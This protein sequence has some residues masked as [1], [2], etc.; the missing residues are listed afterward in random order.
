MHVFLLPPLSASIVAILTVIPVCVC[1]RVGVGGGS[2]SCG[3][4]MMV[5]GVRPVVWLVGG[6]VDGL[7]AVILCQVVVIHCLDGFVLGVRVLYVLS[8]QQNKM[9]N[10]PYFESLERVMWDVM[11]IRLL[12]KD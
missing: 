10:S 3:R 7:L 1:V 6:R 11:K 4:V 2:C 9:R 8:K 5:V 12:R